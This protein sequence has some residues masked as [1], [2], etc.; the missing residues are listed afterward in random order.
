M[1]VG[2]SVAVLIAFA[3]FLFALMWLGWRKRQ[4]RSEPLIG[5]LPVAPQQLGEP[6]LGGIAGIYISSTTHG[7]WLDRVA[8]QD[9]GFRSSGTASVF[10]HGVLIERQGAQDVYIPVEHI[11]SVSQAPG[12]AGKF[13]GGEGIVVIE[14]HLAAKDSNEETQL[15]TGFRTSHKADHALLVNAINQIIS[16]Q[17]Q[18]KES[19]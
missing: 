2:Q 17:P 4:R 14:W 6:E 13:V 8:A 11:S 3:I 19:K 5:A 15:D 12:I 10:S 9:L 16:S 1:T 18:V 7:D